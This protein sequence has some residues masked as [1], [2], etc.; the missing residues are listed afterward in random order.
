M[1]PPARREHNCI[2][3]QLERPESPHRMHQ[4]Y[5]VG[6][7]PPEKLETVGAG[8]DGTADANWA[9]D[10]GMAPLRIVINTDALRSDPGMSCFS[11]SDEVQGQACTPSQLLTPAKV[12]LLEEELM[13]RA[14]AFFSRLL[15]VTP[16]AGNLRLGLPRCGFS[17][18]V[19][20]PT[21]YAAHGIPDA[22]IVFF[23]T[24]RPIGAQSGADTI[25][26][27]GHCEVDQFG[28]PVAAHFNWSP[29]HLDPPESSFESEYL[30]RV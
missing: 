22:D 7:S 12:H 30:L 20:I 6:T 3:G 28:R 16:V 2:H 14:V 18:G 24:A 9:P 19:Q 26:Y 4:P 8:A 1:A 27:S 13:P 11:A 17:G 25:A 10:D 29:E 21:G 15:R 5:S 23:V